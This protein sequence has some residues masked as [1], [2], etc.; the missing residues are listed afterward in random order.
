MLLALRVPNRIFN[1]V[2][3]PQPFLP[4]NAKISPFETERVTLF[5]TVF[6]PKDLWTF[7]ILS[8]CKKELFK[9]YKYNGER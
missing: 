3:F 1:S 6:F 7:L 8:V 9:N 4:Y 5:K 2:D